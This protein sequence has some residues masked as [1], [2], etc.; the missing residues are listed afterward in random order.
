MKLLLLSL[1]AVV[2]IELCLADNLPLADKLLDEKANPLNEIN[3]SE[4]EEIKAEEED[5][6]ASHTTLFS[7]VTNFAK[8]SK[9]RASEAYAFTNKLLQD[10]LFTIFTVTALGTAYKFYILNREIAALQKGLL[11]HEGVLERILPVIEVFNDQ[12]KS[13]NN[14]FGV[15]SFTFVAEEAKISKRILDLQTKIHQ[16]TVVRPSIV[17]E[18]Q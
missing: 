17:E 8:K 5:V 14:R 6:E 9:E 15:L 3:P 13:L 7:R 16:A 2:S 11:Y 10:N 18:G 1:L 4:G 12:I